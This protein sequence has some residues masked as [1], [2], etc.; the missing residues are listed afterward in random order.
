[1]RRNFWLSSVLICA[2]SVGVIA[3]A[4]FFYHTALPDLVKM[5]A[6][7]VRNEYREV[8]QEL[9]EHPETATHLQRGKGSDWAMEGRMAPGR[10]GMHPA[11]VEGYQL[12][13]YQPDTD[14][15]EILATTVETIPVR[16]FALYSTLGGLGIVLLVVGMS[17]VGM[18]YLIVYGRSRDDFMAATAHDLI[19]PLVGLR[20]MIGRNDEEARH[21]TERLLRLVQNVQD[22]LRLGGRRKK[23][24][25]HPFDVR[26]AYESAYQ[27]FR[28]DFRDWFEG[29]DVAVECPKDL[30]PAQ[31]DELLTIQ[32][33]WNL[34]GNSLKYAAPFGRVKVVFAVD[35]RFVT[36]ACVDEG[37]GM[38]KHEM[39][40]A[41]DRYYRA[42]TILKSGKGGFGIGLCTSRE[43]ARE[44]GGN[45]TLHPNHPKG[46]VFTLSLPGVYPFFDR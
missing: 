33:L 27:S 16:N 42:K 43:F 24:D 8:A 14:N 34:L 35:G 41:F 38:T 19:T 29:E 1:M 28:E 13:W 32:I 18:R 15:P 45:L 39:R 12:V 7:R 40:H 22:F 4:V 46:C 36:V 9:K 10:W 31:G 17:L 20:G 3:C 6:T 5:E 26:Q 11:V 37:Q 2:P 44:M 30:P 25:C 23:P 21:L